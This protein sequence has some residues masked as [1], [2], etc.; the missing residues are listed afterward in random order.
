MVLITK[1]RNAVT[2]PKRPLG[3]RLLAGR[4]VKTQALWGG[5]GRRKPPSSAALVVR[6]DDARQGLELVVR[7]RRGQGPFQRRRTFTPR[8]RSGLF[9]ADEGINY[10]EHEDEETGEEDIGADGGHH[11][12]AR[13]GVRIIRVAA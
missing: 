2:R 4:L 10:A 11:V 1:F 12:P 6:V 8:V 7:R 9:L 3:G 5:A 13:E